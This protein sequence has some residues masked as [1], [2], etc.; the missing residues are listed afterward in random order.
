MNDH[1]RP[2]LPPGFS[3]LTT[4]KGRV[5]GAI[6]WTTMTLFWK[7]GEDSELIDLAAHR[8]QALQTPTRDKETR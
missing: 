1:T 5:I 3:W 8:A 4:S 2:P 7:K 6:N